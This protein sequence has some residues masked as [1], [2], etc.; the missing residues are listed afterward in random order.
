[1]KKSRNHGNLIDRKQLK[2]NSV[3]TEVKLHIGRRLENYPR[4]SLRLLALHSGVS[5]GSAWT[6]T[7]LLHI[8]PF[9][10][11]IAPEIEPVYYGT[12]VRLCNWFISHVHDGLLDLKLTLFTDEANFNLAG[13]VN[14]QNNRY[15]SSENPHTLIQLPFHDQELGVWC[16]I[17]A[18]RYH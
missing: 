3:L 4:K 9:K 17:S 7:K 12:R 6:A 11:T 14:S 16:A 1:V 8:R 10:I 18:S 13:Y 5:V 2:I 15:W